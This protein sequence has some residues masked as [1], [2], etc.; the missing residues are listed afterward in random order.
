MSGS[1]N[2]ANTDY[3]NIDKIRDIC[4]V[5]IM[6]NNN[7]ISAYLA[8]TQQKERLGLPVSKQFI[9][10]DVP[11]N[12]LSNGITLA[13][14]PTLEMIGA[15]IKAKEVTYSYFDLPV[16]LNTSLSKVI[17]ANNQARSIVITKNTDISS[18]YKFSFQLSETDYETQFYGV[19]KNVTLFF[20]LM[21]T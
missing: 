10:I 13:L 11:E 2:L 19:V 17:Y 1:Q 18:M 9:A 5:I 20:T 21:N 12:I 8:G 4:K 7:T 15:L 3:Q 14:N 16:V 6:N